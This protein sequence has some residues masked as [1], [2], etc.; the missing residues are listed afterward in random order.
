LGTPACAFHHGVAFPTVVGGLGGT[1]W[2]FPPATWLNAEEGVRVHTYVKNTEVSVFYWHGHQY[3]AN[4][5]VSGP[6]GH[7]F[8][9]L[10][11]PH[12]DDVGITGNSPLYLPGTLGQLLPFVIRA[13]GVFQDDAPL[14]NNRGFG[15]NVTY[16]STINTLVALDLTSAYAPWLT[17]T[18]TLTANLE[19]NNTTILSPSKTMVYSASALHRYHNEEQFLLSLGTSFLWNEFQP[20]LTGIYNPDGTLFQV[21]PTIL[22]QPHWTSN[23]TLRLQYIGIFGNNKYAP[24]GGLYK[25]KSLF[26]GT[27]QYNFNL[28]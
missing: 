13:E 15:N 7:Q 16:T 27:F 19:W 18:G 5:F 20:N 9:T 4:H 21:F 14:N 2:A 3:G 6:P 26:V 23:Y 1:H 22:L 17:E 28:L 8:L 25:G 11:F 24:Q 12:F 10:R